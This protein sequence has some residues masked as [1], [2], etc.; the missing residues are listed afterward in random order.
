MAK[1]GERSKLEIELKLVGAPGDVAA[2]RHSPLIE[3]VARGEERAARLVSTYYD[4]LD[5]ALRAAGVSLRLREGAGKRLQTM[6]C[7]TKGRGAVARIEEERALAFGEAFPAVVKDPKA[8]KLIAGARRLDPVARISVDRWTRCLE[9][10]PT[11]IEAAFD[12]GRLEAWRAGVPAHAGPI[13]EAELELI[14]GEPRD[15]FDLAAAILI[16]SRGC[17][18]P[19][20]FSKAEQAQRLGQRQTEIAPEAVIKLT[21]KDDAADALAIALRAIAARIAEVEPA[22]T[23]LRLAEGVHQM[24]VALRRLR[25]LERTY[26]DDLK[27]NELR[28][29]A[30]AAR[31]FASELGPARDWDVFLSETLP[32]LERAGE[33]LEGLR[34][35]RARGDALRAA[36]W[37]RAR[38]TIASPDFAEFTLELMAAGHLEAWRCKARKCLAEPARAFAA[39]ALD[40][41]LAEAEEAALTIDSPDPAACHPLRIALKKLRYTA[42]TFSTAFPRRARKPYMA[43]LSRLQDDLGAVN[44]AVTA[45]RLANDAALGQGRNAARASGFIAGFHAAAG[46]ARAEAVGEDWRAFAATAP[47]WRDKE[48]R[49]LTEESS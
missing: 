40:E 45:Q 30:R 25:S 18:R 27:T 29:L 2:L 14:E 10:G 32:P 35:I 3:A 39:A 28:G 4:T 1:G 38:Q 33:E 19:G 17:L 5:G 9:N 46:R 11:R 12:I 44:D 8:A 20:I 31:G 47:F 36:A 24:R 34:E 49:A 43:A 21:G 42:Q 41:R 22:V 26:R 15:L 13:A 16:E 48:E 23:E 6:K 7:E 37:E